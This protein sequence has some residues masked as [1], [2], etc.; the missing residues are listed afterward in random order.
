[1]MKGQGK[2]QVEEGSSLT[3]AKAKEIHKML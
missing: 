1:M 3:K 2:E